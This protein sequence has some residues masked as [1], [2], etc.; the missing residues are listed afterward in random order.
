MFTPL[1]ENILEKYNE[2][3]ESQKTNAYAKAVVQKS[4]DKVLGLHY[5]GPHAG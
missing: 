2:E 3:G 1:E 5:A 4:N